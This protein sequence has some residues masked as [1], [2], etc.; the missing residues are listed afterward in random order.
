[1]N[2]RQPMMKKVL[3]TRDKR[4]VRRRLARLRERATE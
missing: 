1:M 2:L 3:Q 4:T